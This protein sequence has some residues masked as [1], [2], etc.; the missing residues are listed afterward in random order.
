[1]DSCLSPNLDP[2]LLLHFH[3]LHA[4]PVNQQ[5]TPNNICLVMKH[6]SSKV[7]EGEFMAY[8]VVDG[9]LI[10]P[11]Q[12]FGEVSVNGYAHARQWKRGV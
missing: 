3:I 4:I 8:N 12:A 9:A 2:S 7:W 6:L 1:M 5:Y 10:C 11:S